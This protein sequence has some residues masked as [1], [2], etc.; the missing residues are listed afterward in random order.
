ME[1][2]V[3]KSDSKATSPG[4][5]SSSDEDY[6]LVEDPAKI[7]ACDINEELIND[8]LGSSSINSPS[9]I[10]DEDEKILVGKSIFYDCN[11]R[12]NSEDSD[13]GL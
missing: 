12:M 8:A 7:I 2:I 4:K 9:T 1:N 5:L 11:D 13:E 3:A 10:N 6:E